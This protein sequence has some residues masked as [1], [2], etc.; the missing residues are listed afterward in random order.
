MK[1]SDMREMITHERRIKALEAHI[2]DI[3]ERFAERIHYVVEMMAETDSDMIFIDQKL[4][5]ILP[6]YTSMLSREDKDPG[7]KDS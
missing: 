7:E 4:G 6:G 5:E 3:E 2:K 1:I